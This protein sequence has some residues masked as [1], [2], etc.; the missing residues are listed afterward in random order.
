MT[1]PRNRSRF[2]ALVSD[3]QFVSSVGDATACYA[4]TYA[5]ASALM[6]IVDYLAW[7]TRW[8]NPPTRGE[9]EAFRDAIILSLQSPTSCDK[10][11]CTHYPP[12]WSWIDYQ[13]HRPGEPPDE[14]VLPSWSYDETTRTVYALSQIGR[15]TPEIYFPLAAN[16]EANIHLVT[17]LLGGKVQIFDGGIF[18]LATVDTYTDLTTIPPETNAEILVPI[19]PAAEDRTITIRF[20]ASF[21]LEE[22]PITFGGGFR[23]ITVCTGS[24]GQMSFQLR[25]TDC[26]LEQST[27]EGATWTT[28]FNYAT[29][30]QPSITTYYRYNETTNIYEQSTDN[31]QTWT[32]ATSSA[33]QMTGYLFPTPTVPAEYDDKCFAAGNVMKAFQDSVDAVVSQLSNAAGIVGVSTAIEGIIAIVLSS[34]TGFGII[35]AITALAGA[36][37]QAGGQAI[38]AAFTEEV[39][40]DFKKIVYCNTSD[41]LTITA[42]GAEGIR[43]QCEAQFTGIVR[44]HFHDLTIML[45]S[46]GLTNFARTDRGVYNALNCECDTCTANYTITEGTLISVDGCFITIQSEP[47]EST[48]TFE[49]VTITGANGFCW[50]FIPPTVFEPANHPHGNYGTGCDNVFY[51]PIITGQ[52][53]KEAMIQGLNN[54][55]QFTVTIDLS[56]PCQ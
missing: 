37:V 35:A 53:V 1:P 13:Y 28:A 51:N 39:W 48:P 46:V 44:Q 56:Y 9:L 32:D 14:L 36:L 3:W 25:Q 20:T 22:I 49:R 33:P 26:L 31:G 5:Q 40:N 19:A 15:S 11:N 43:F 52:C 17:V 47:I 34:L 54:G 8:E 27:D 6:S 18:P 50:N 42:A 41:G 10:L 7:P 30:I 45:G 24:A 16:T 55:G 12:L 4:L 2:N 21:D 29:C 23:G 38:A